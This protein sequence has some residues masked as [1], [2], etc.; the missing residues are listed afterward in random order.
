MNPPARTG[1]LKGFERR[2]KLADPLEPLH[3]LDNGDAVANTATMSKVLSPGMRLG[4]VVKPPDHLIRVVDFRQHMDLG[5]RG[6][7]QQIL[8]H[9]IADGHLSR[10]IPKG[11]PHLRASLRQCGPVPRE[12]GQD[13][14]RQQPKGERR[15]P[16][17]RH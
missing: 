13:R 2:Q 7:D 11:P 16:C 6:L 10:H 1:R 14:S 17:F 9:Y 8:R 15:A 3:R 5:P 12:R 4:Y